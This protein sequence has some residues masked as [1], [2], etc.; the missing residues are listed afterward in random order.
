MHWCHH[1]HHQFCHCIMAISRWDRLCC[2][3]CSLKPTHQTMY[4]SESKPLFA[5]PAHTEH[6]FCSATNVATDATLMSSMAYTHP[7][8]VL[9]MCT[10]PPIF[11]NQ[12]SHK[13]QKCTCM[14]DHGDL[15]TQVTQKSQHT[16]RRTLTVTNYLVEAAKLLHQDMTPNTHDANIRTC[17]DPIVCAK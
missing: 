6:C 9:L 12:T 8:I 5:N 16:H 4:T 2:K 13:H 10:Q 17:N 7:H 1:A 14:T 3:Q 15:L 11:A